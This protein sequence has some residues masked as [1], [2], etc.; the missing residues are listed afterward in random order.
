MLFK[1]DF[2]NNNKWLGKA[3]MVEAEQKEVL[4]IEQYG[5]RKGKAARIQCLNKKIVLQLHQSKKNTHSFMFEQCKELL[6]T[7]YSHYCGTVLVLLGGT[8]ES[9]GEH[10]RYPSAT[11]TSRALS[12]W[13]FYTSSRTRRMDRTNSRNRTREWRR[14]TNLGS[15]QHLLIQNPT[16]GRFCRHVYLCSNQTTKTNGRL[17]FCR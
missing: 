1:A 2:N 12:I 13:K 17:C 14:A 10:D 6:Q 16:R 11:M 9:N 4:T 8:K 7:N 15:H 3:I 5:S